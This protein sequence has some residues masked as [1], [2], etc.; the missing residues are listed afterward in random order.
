MTFELAGEELRARVTVENHC[1][2]LLREIWFP[3]LSGVRELD[4]HT[5]HHLLINYSTGLIMD[6]PYVNLPHY[7][8][9]TFGNRPGGRFFT[10]G[11]GKYPLL[12]PGVCAMPWM[13]YYDARQGW[14]LGYHDHD[15]PSTGLLMRTRDV[16]EDI[17]LGFVRYPMIQP[18]TRWESGTFVIC[19]HEGDWHA[20]SKRY[21]A[22]AAEKIGVTHAPD[23]LQNTSGFHIVSCIGQD[24]GIHHSYSHIY[25]TFKA[26]CAS[27]VDLPLVV[28]GWVKRGF[29]NGY[30]ELDPDE[31]IGGAEALRSVIRQV[32]VEGGKVLLYTQGR[33]I[34]MCTDFYKQI[35][36]D[37]CCVSEDG[38]PYVDE[39]SFNAEATIYPNRLFAL[40]CPST[41][42]WEDQLK[43][44]ID[45]VMDLGA[46]GLLYDQ[47]GADQAFICFN[48]AHEHASP[49]MAF[50]GKIQM[51]ENLQQ[52]AAAKNPGFAIMGELICDVFLQKLDITHGWETQD[53]PDTPPYMH[54]CSEIYRYTFPSHRPSCR[55]AR[56]QAGYN[57]AFVNGMALEHSDM[58]LGN[59]AIV[60]HAVDLQKLR[61]RLMPFFNNS[62]FVDEDGLVS[63]PEAV[64]AKRY[65][66][67][68]GTEGVAIANNSEKPMI[69]RIALAARPGGK[70]TLYRQTGSQEEIVAEVGVFHIEIPGLQA[71]FLIISPESTQ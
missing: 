16:E 26:D 43:K 10:H 28:F 66:G 69:A 6:D 67:A 40:S 42:A 46:D 47:I 30:P 53:G 27:G 23:W 41:K 20:G 31:R 11:F 55:M 33:L 24:R 22:F 7:D 49:D 3:F 17:Q 14:Y 59:D 63:Q 61:A 60:R 64:L 37:C 13:D 12:Y 8:G 44:Q 29:D 68:D 18:G 19:A 62:R 71:A 51:L 25:E 35:G 36:H 58:R 1:D 21:Q 52:Y 34:D 15:T 9:Q 38:V 5:R 45:I 32:Q 2:D 56:T 70:A 65:V 57:T 39:Y 50:H 54:V 48:P 4:K